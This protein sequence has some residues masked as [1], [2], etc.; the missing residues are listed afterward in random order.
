MNT[1]DEDNYCMNSQE[2]PEDLGIDPGATHGLGKVGYIMV[3]QDQCTSV[4][5]YHI[6]LHYGQSCIN[7]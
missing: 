6:A 3:M 1:K 4:F 7:T 5:I 2:N